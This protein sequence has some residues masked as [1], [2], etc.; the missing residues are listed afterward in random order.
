M[1]YKIAGLQAFATF[2]FII[3]VSAILLLFTDTKAQNTSFSFGTDIPYQ[4]YVGVNVETNH[5]DISYRT[6]ILV[7]PYSDAI[8][9]ILEEFG[10]DEIYIDLL[11]AAYNFGWMNS[12]GAYYK[13]GQQKRWYT[14][15]E[16][17]FDYLSAADS[18]ADLLEVVVG[19][20]IPNRLQLNNKVQL[21]LAMYAV[22]I[23]FGRSFSIGEN[24]KHSIKAEF[25]FSKHIATNSS[26]LINNKSAENI[27]LILDDLLWED[28]FKKYGFIGGL[29]VAYHYNF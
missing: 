9:S 11:D 14:G 15:A 12:I 3:V 25:S 18:P 27:N 22:G 24:E 6:G 13:I 23:R 16:F 10:T 7:P 17:R 20:P 26:L 1:L 2:R 4:H 28:V 21:G 29:G 5:V 19:E 8:L